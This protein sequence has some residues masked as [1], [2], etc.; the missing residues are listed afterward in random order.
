MVNKKI[1]WNVK[2][3]FEKQ[4]NKMLFL[5]AIRNTIQYIHSVITELLYFT[6]VYCY[7]NSDNINRLL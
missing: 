3:H 2:Q 1:N 6:F 7:L 4:N 5:K